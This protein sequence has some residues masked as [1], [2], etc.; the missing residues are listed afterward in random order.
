MIHP[1]IH[2][3]NH[4]VR[5]SRGSLQD[6]SRSLQGGSRLLLQGREGDLGGLGGH[7]LGE[8]G[9]FRELLCLGRRRGPLKSPTA[10]DLSALKAGEGRVHFA[11]RTGGRIGKKRCMV[12]A[13]RVSRE[14]EFV[15]ANRRDPMQPSV[16]TS[17]FP[18]AGRGMS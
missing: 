9:E 11:A 10:G 3:R 2:G 4:Q 18:G 6:F 7:R 16:H 8:L 5:G 15:V 13:L 12:T 17:L 14:V 1:S